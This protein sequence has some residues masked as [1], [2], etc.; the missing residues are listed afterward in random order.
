MPGFRLSPAAQ[1][2]LEKIFDYTARQWGLEQA[3]DYTQLLANACATFAEAP[4]RAQD[5]GHV[6]PGYRRGAAGQ[7]LIYFR[8]EDDGIAVIRILHA[9]MDTPRHL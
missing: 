9:R 6:R 1:A 4:A 2:D 3:V 5:C 8:V 7:H